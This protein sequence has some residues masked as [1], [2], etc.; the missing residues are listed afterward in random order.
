MTRAKKKVRAPKDEVINVRLTKQ[1]KVELDAAAAREG[2]GL[3]TWLLRLGLL[4]VAQERNE[5]R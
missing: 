5:H 2:L 1:Q 3:S 4:L